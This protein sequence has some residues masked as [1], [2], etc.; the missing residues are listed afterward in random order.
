[1]VRVSYMERGFNSRTVWLA[2][3]S[4]VRVEIGLGVGEAAFGGD[5]RWS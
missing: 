5:R 3:R 1:M 2:V 4:V